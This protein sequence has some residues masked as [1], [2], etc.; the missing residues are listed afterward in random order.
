MAISYEI[1][2]PYFEGLISHSAHILNED[3]LGYHSD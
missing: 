3:Y 2:L 1:S